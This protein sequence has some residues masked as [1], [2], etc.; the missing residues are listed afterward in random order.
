MRQLV[1]GRDRRCYAVRGAVAIPACS[2]RQPGWMNPHGIL[3]FSGRHEE[4]TGQEV[5]LDFDLQCVIVLS[6]APV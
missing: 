3:G 2:K 6:A 5:F 4:W 1:S